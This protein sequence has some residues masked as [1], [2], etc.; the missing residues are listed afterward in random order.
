MFWE[1]WLKEGFYLIFEME[2]LRASEA[3]M[4]SSV[5]NRCAGQNKCADGKIL[6]KTSDVQDRIDMQ[7]KII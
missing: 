3:S 7:W 6:K 2:E 1:F 4:Y 5:P